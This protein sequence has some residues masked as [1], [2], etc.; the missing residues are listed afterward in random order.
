MGC[1][2]VPGHSCRGFASETSTRVEAIGSF[3]QGKKRT[4][5][6][7]AGLEMVNTTGKHPMPPFSTNAGGISKAADCGASSPGL[8]VIAN[9]SGNRSCTSRY[10]ISTASI[11][12]RNGNL[13]T[14]SLRTPGSSSTY[15]FTPIG[16]AL[17]T[18]KKPSIFTPAHPHSSHPARAI[19]LS[20]AA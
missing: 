19:L 11:E 7:V 1:E 3:D 14:A 20:E 5:E 18:R 16:S 15:R 12:T 10:T 6:T 2:G 9:L 13:G 4:T 8:T 17:L